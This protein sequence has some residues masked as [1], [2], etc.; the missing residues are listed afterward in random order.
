M[1]LKI[2]LFLH[3]KLLIM[4]T[5]LTTSNIGK[6]I[7]TFVSVKNIKGTSFVGVKNYENKEGEISNQTFL[8]GINYEN[9]LKTDYDKLLNFDLSTLRLILIRKH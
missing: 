2:T 7:A 1:V 6:T 8:V 3:S 9:L 5:V 4:T